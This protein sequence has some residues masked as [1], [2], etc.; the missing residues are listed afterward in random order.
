MRV[1]AEQTADEIRLALQR[2]DRLWDGTGV[3]HQGRVGVHVLMGGEEAG[4]WLRFPEREA[5]L[6]GTQDMLLSRA[7]NRGYASPR[8]RWPMEFGLLNQDCLWV[9]DEVQLMDVGLATSGQLQ[10]SRDLVP[11]PRPSRS[12]WMSATLQRSWLTASPETRG[13]GPSLALRSIPQEGRHG[14]L[15][16]DVRKPLS[17]MAL[18]EKEFARLVAECHLASGRGARGPTLVVVNRVERAQE[19]HQLLQKDNSL[20]GSDLRLAHSR[21]RSSERAAWR[22][23]FLNRAACGPGTDRIIVSTQVVEAGVDC[24]AGQLIT[25]LAPWASLV[26]RF[27]RC[28]RWGGE[29]QVVVVDLG[30]TKDKDA[31]PYGLEE[32]AAAREALS[33]LADVT[34]GHL[35]LFEEEHPELLARLY[36]YEPRHLLL[37]HEVDDLFDT[38]P[39]LSGADIDI[40]RFIRSG[41]ERDLQ[42][43]WRTIEGSSPDRRWRPRREELCAVP[44]HTAREWLCGAESKSNPSPRLKEKARAWV[45][46]WLEGIWRWAERR[47]LYPGQLVLVDATCGGYNPERGFSPASGSPVPIPAAGGQVPAGTSDDAQDDESTSACPW[48]TIASHGRE[49]G[50]L[51]RELASELIP[52]LARVLELAG[53]W[54]DAGKVFPAFQDSIRHANRPGRHDLAKAPSGAWLVGRALYPM[55]GGHRPGFRHELISTLA[56]FSVLRR[57][58]P[59]HP[60]LLGPWR[61][62]WTSMGASVEWAA[63]PSDPPTPLEQE[64]LALSPGQFDLLAYLVCSH[65]GKLRVSWHAAPV[66]QDSPTPAPRLRGV[67]EGDSVPAVALCDK[68]GQ[69]WELP[70][71]LAELELAALGVGERFGASWSERSLG[72]LRTHGPFALAWLEALLRAADQRC[73]RDERTADPLLEESGQ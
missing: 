65:H 34:P 8:A 44:F 22:A 53:R 39:D 30:H 66:D 51:A 41:V 38:T 72:L 71:F 28:A 58:Q 29:A 20:R 26:Q 40:S 32:L 23:E 13:C 24:S 47:D 45:W 3:P 31:A 67:Q 5:V 37:P 35:E 43:F 18:S 52:E 56:L 4:D 10:A 21:F 9:L 55:E 15:W 16:D 70:G 57:H 25:E 49:T 14:H 68:Q 6:V 64:I 36:P 1:L 12:W 7:L 17:V 50:Q 60:A 27:G 46:D 63:A 61:E 11:G 48:K 42:V 59:D 2:V 73:S 19:L 69:P 33:M 54:H 62:L